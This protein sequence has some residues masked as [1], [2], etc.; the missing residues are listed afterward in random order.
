MYPLREIVHTATLQHDYAT[1][2][3]SLRSKL[4]E[5]KVE[6]ETEDNAR[7][8][9]VARWLD[10]IFSLTQ[11]TCWY[12][13]FAEV[14]VAGTGEVV[15]IAVQFLAVTTLTILAE[16]Y[17]SSRLAVGVLAVC[18]LILCWLNW[19]RLK[20]QI[21]GAQGHR[22]AFIVVCV[23]VFAGIGAL[24]GVMLTQSKA[25]LDQKTQE[26]EK[27]PTLADLFRTD[28]PNVLK[29]TDDAFSLKSGTDGT[30]LPVKRQVYMDFG[31]KTQ[32]VGYYIAFRP[33][34]RENQAFDASIALIDAVKPTIDI[35]DRRVT[36]GG[37]ASGVTSAQALVFSGRVFLYHE[38]PLTN[39]QKADIVRAYSARHYDVNFR[40]LD[41]LGERVSA[42]YQE[43]NATEPH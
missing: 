13:H 25:G 23:V 30:V 2:F 15:K 34:N 18:I 10:V 28:F 4:Q 8:V 38:Q 1:T 11:R 21:H 35:L 39:L 20:E 6:V 29:A 9:I 24:V 31:A 14:Y 37:D 33:S 32:F 26:A 36:S 27:P 22:T 17:L 12:A 41:Y 43:H 16:R 19:N 5:S 40:G 7:G 3:S 42:W